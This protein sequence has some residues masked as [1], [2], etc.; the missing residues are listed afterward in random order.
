MYAIAD[1]YE[2]AG[3][4]DMAKDKFKK[5][6]ER[7]WNDPLFPTAAA[8][9]FSSTPDKDLGLRDVV[10]DT[11]ANHVKLVNKAEIFEFMAE[12]ATVAVSV[13]KKRVEAGLE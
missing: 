1:K 7:F 2:V 11:I 10:I 4:G 6:C 8:H 5:A 12:N 13:L 3:L 9:V